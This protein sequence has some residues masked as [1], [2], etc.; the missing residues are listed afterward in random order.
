CAR[1]IGGGGGRLQGGQHDA[2]PPRGGAASI[3]RVPATSREATALLDEEPASWERSPDQQTRWFS[4]RVELVQGRERWIVVVTEAGLAR[5][6]DLDQTG[7]AGPGPLGAPALAP[8]ESVV[9]L[10]GRCGGR[11]AAPAQ[12]P[13]GLAA[14]SEHAEQPAAL[15]AQRTSLQGPATRPRDLARAGTGE[16]RRGGARARG[17]QARSLPRSDHSARGHRIY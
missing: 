13:A 15:R 17:A 3:S 2:L 8:Q 6:R 11:T 14:G 4:R 9:R 16:Q 12:D 10:S 1:E 5:A 7:S